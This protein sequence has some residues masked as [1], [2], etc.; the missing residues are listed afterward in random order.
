MVAFLQSTIL[1]SLFFYLPTTPI[2]H[3]A[4][5][6]PSWVLYWSF[7]LGGHH[8]RP[9]FYIQ[10]SVL[11]LSLH[12]LFVVFCTADQA[13]LL[14]IYTLDFHINNEDTIIAFYFSEF[15]IAV[16]LF[17]NISST[18]MV[19][20]LVISPFPIASKNHLEIGEIKILYFYTKLIPHF[21]MCAIY[22]LRVLQT[23]PKQKFS[24]SDRFLTVAKP[25]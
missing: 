21:Q 3:V 14:S 18:C 7:I 10:W 25:N 20:S 6:L 19:F 12:D 17:L 8:W 22:S 5:W 16:S 23:F 1:L 15:P 13:S 4:T 2:W 24:Y 11:N 9:N